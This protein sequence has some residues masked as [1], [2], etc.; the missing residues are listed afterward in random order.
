[1]RSSVVKREKKVR[2][3]DRRGDE[4]NVADQVKMMQHPQ[5]KVASVTLE[6]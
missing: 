4:V 3:T 5:W 1:M 2:E 6:R